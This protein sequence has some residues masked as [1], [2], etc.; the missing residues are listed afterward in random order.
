MVET[1]TGPYSGRM[2]HGAHRSAADLLA[3]DFPAVHLVAVDLVPDSVVSPVRCGCSAT[4]S[5]VRSAGCSRCAG[6]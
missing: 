6:W 2:I 5:P 3:V 1:S 4:S